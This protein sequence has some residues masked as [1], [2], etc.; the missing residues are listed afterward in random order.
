M[1][2]ATERPSMF[3]PWAIYIYMWL[4]FLALPVILFYM[5]SQD[6][7]ARPIEFALHGM[8]PSP[9]GEPST[10]FLYALSLITFLASIVAPAIMRANVPEGAPVGRYLMSYIVRLCL[11]E[12]GV[13]VGF[14]LGLLKTKPLVIVPFLLIG[15]LG[16]FFSPP[17]RPA[18]ART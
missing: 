13:L 9:A 4:L 18:T 8:V 2:P 7:T 3:V 14:I 1:Q 12:G 17:K 16:L 10:L 11:I 15:A 5:H 6:P